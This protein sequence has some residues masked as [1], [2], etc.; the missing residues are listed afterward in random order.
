M[1]EFSLCNVCIRLIINNELLPLFYNSVS[2]IRLVF[3]PSPPPPPPLIYYFSSLTSLCQFQEP[4]EM[5]LGHRM[6]LNR[7]VS[8]P[9][10]KRA[11]DYI[12]HIP[13]LK[14][15][16]CLLSNQLVYDEVQW[17]MYIRIT[18]HYQPVTNTHLSCVGYERSHKK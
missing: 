4:I 8:R 18:I 7:R 15:L 12:Y 5:T 3:P 9:Y 11:N 14:S 2:L 17:Y 6:V 10:L 1:F 16:Q 13:L